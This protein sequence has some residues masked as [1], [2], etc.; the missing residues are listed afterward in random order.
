MSSTPQPSPPRS[1][2]AV[3]PAVADAVV[4]IGFALVG[5]GSHAET[6]DMRGVI[7]TAWPFLG[8]LALG[9]VATRAWRTPLRVFPTGLGIWGSTVTI[10]LLLRLLSDQGNAP[11]FVIVTAV[12][13]GLGLLGWRACA[14]LVRRRRPRPGQIEV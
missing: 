4:V 13:L 7:A 11:G 12:V 5:R 10:G 8:G 6:V 1:R 14:L 2:A 3:V 9:W